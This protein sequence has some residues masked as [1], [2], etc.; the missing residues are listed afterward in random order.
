MTSF[1][2]LWENMRGR[3]EDSKAMS[4]IR[5]GLNT[6]EEFWDK[7]LLVINNSDSV[8]ALLDISRDKVAGWHARIRENLAKVREADDVPDPK[9]RGKLLHAGNDDPFGGGSEPE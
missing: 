9:K 6:D 7:F 8:A 4:A 1:Q 5:T 2:K 3:E